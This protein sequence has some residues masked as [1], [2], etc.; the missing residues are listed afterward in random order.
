MSDEVVLTPF[1]SFLIDPADI[2]G[3]TT[4]AGTLWDGPGFLQPIAKEFGELGTEGVTILDVGANI[5]TFSIWLAKHGAWRVIAVEPV[6][7]T[8]RYLKANLDL[9]KTFCASRVVPLEIAAFNA[10]VRMRADPIDPGNLG[11]TALS[12]DPTGAIQA[13]RLDNWRHCFGARVSLIKVDAQGCDG[14]A[15]LGLTDTIQRDRPAIVFEW[16]AG[17]A[18]RH[19]LDLTDVLSWLQGTLHYN[20]NPWP[21]YANNYLATSRT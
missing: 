14:K 6:P 19:G 9:N 16:E 4:K 15:L 18:Q 12:I 17:L 5:G 2:I 7:L 10:T 1:G 8:L 13:D 3:S 20:V 21:C 11:G